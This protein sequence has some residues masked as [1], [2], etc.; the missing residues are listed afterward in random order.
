MGTLLL[1]GALSFQLPATVV[2]GNFC[3]I[4]F[5]LVADGSAQSKSAQLT[6]GIL[7]SIADQASPIFREEWLDNPPRFCSHLINAPTLLETKSIWWME[8]R[9][10]W[11][12]HYS[13]P[14]LWETWQQEEREREKKP[15]KLIALG[16]IHLFARKSRGLLDEGI[17]QQQCHLTNHHH[18][19]N[20]DVLAE[21]C[22]SLFFRDCF[23]W[24]QGCV[25]DYAAMEHAC[26][27][28]HLF[29]CG[30]TE[31]RPLPQPR[32]LLRVHK[33]QRLVGWFGWFLQ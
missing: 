28:F 8:T 14:I 25:C 4:A 9:P 27:L 15:K 22:W 1:I 30:T 26:G 19:R 12:I 7:F 2:P 20:N 13:W 32:E 10:T 33:R 21:V 16:C 29:L 23:R 3:W 5:A 18:H 6:T 17:Q 11:R 31:R 24:R